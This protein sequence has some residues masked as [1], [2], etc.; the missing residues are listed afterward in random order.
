MTDLRTCSSRNK[1]QVEND[2]KGLHKNAK[3]VLQKHVGTEFSNQTVKPNI[4]LSKPSSL[5]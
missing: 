3:T 1:K 2:Y 4:L 5:I